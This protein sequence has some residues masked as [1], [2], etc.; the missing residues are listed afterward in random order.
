MR[1]LFSFSF[2]LFFFTNCYTQTTPRMDSILMEVEN[3]TADEKLDL[4]GEWFEN[5]IKEDI[6]LLLPMLDK[7]YENAILLVGQDSAVIWQFLRQGYL[8]KKFQEFG[9]AN[10]SIQILDQMKITSDSLAKRKNDTHWTQVKWY[11]SVGYFSYMQS[12]LGKA[13]KYYKKAIKLNEQLDMPKESFEIYTRLSFLK[14]YEKSFEEA[15]LY[16]NLA[17]SLLNYISISNQ[18]KFTFYYS[19]AFLHGE[20]GAAELENYYLTTI[21]D[22]LHLFKKIMALRIETDYARSLCEIGKTEDCINYFKKLRPILE[23]EENIGTMVVFAEKYSE[24]LMLAGDFKAG[25]KWNGKWRDSYI[26]IQEARRNDEVQEWQV[27]YE[28]N[29]K[30]AKIQLLEQQK[31][32]SQNRLINFSLIALFSMGLL[33]F[34]IYRNRN[35]K[36]QLALQLNRDREITEN[37]DRLFSSI[38]HDIRTPLSL[39]LAPMERAENRITDNLAK[40]DIQLARR[41]GKRLMELFNQILDWNK[42]E[43]KALRLNSQVGQLDFTFHAL[44][45]RFEQQASEKG[46]TFSQNVKMPK[47]QFLLD[48]DKLD[49]I[50][51]NLIG[52][53]IKFSDAKGKVNL[54]AEVKKEENEYS[55]ALIVGD[56]GPGIKVDEQKELFQRFVQGEQGE[57]KGGTGIGLA[58]VKELVDL[59]KGEIQFQ[60]ELGKGTTFK[61]KLPVE[62][63]DELPAPSLQQPD[64]FSTDPDS[65][66][67]VKPSLL[68]VEDE[69]E[70]LSFLKAALSDSYKIEIANSTTAGL[71]VAINRIPEIIISDWTLPDNNGGWF[72]QQIAANELTAHI[73]ILI[74]TAH[75]SD[76]N[77]KEAL[78]AGAVAWMNKPFD[79]GMLKKQLSTILQQQQRVQK[80][81]VNKIAPENLNDKKELIEVDPFMQKVL[82]T[83]E[84]S[85]QDDQ[86]S[87]EKLAGSLFLSRI[88]LFR[89]VK[90]ITGRGPSKLINE[91]R[92]KKARQILK[93]SEKSIAEIAYQVGFSDPNYFGKVY[94]EYFKITPSQDLANR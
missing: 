45:Q 46:V 38:T 33:S 65:K 72:C 74:L 69:P 53:A 3:A 18:K 37:R 61:V 5:P 27:K 62:L 91:F 52:N 42:A 49:K 67:I 88:Q 75:S 51:S 71:N 23:K 16:H 22:S 24:A 6:P 63:I 68:I 2:L 47:G 90:N 13:E 32:N 93:H 44:S 28:A 25:E 79:L 8:V 92:L 31:Q 17:D 12:D 64:M 14:T 20:M 48:Y 76:S 80:N 10:L 57:L 41:N 87:V 4:W 15:L 9:H 78:D 89:K 84:S 7:A 39:M 40:S 36:K 73:P 1:F 83:I 94:K 60:S 34:F 82:G 77:Q 35:Q 50:L 59:M 58:L 29:E 54:S 81:W 55:L 43:A 11:S 86:F 21:I 66:S 85:Y 26:Q 56:Q 19:K 30:E 70:L